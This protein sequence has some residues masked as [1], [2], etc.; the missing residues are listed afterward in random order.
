MGANPNQLITTLK[1]AEAHKGPSLN[2]ACAPCINHGISNVMGV[3]QTEEQCAKRY[4]KYQ[5][6]AEK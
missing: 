3:A 1:E 6:L 4:A 5:K 2:I